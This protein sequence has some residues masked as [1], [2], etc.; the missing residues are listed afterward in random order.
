[1]ADSNKPIVPG[2]DTVGTVGE[3]YLSKNGKTYECVAV[4]DNTTIT[5]NGET[6]PRVEY[7]WVCTDDGAGGGAFPF[8]ISDSEPITISRTK[9]ELIAAIDAGKTPIGY[10]LHT[11]SNGTVIRLFHFV[12]RFNATDGTNL[13]FYFSDK[14]SS[15]VLDIQA[16]GTI[17]RTYQNTEPGGSGLPEGATAFQQLVTDSKG[18]AV[19]DDRPGGY[20]QKIIGDYVY[21]KGDDKSAFYKFCQKNGYKIG[22]TITVVCNGVTYENVPI[23]ANDNGGVHLEQ[24]GVFSF[25]NVTYWGGGTWGSASDVFPDGVVEA[26]FKNVHQLNDVV[27]PEKYMAYVLDKKLDKSGGDVSGKLRVAGEDVLLQI[28]NAPME[29]EDEKKIY[30]ELFLG[31]SNVSIRSTYWPIMSGGHNC[32]QLNS[33]GLILE[34]T[35]SDDVETGSSEDFGNVFFNYPVT[36]QNVKT[37]TVSTD[38][39]NMGY[40]DDTKLIV[41]SSTAGSTKKFKITVDDAGTL[42]A[43][44]ITT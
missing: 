2:G 33:R 5:P 29:G 38:A 27:I 10:W 14:T 43:T 40:V 35:R 24:S 19:W 44:E 30:H 16:D 6:I 15:G 22:D 21:A 39:A 31:D 7:V 8:D 9:E 18:S 28:V 32:L 37:P 26:T 34:L 4:I 20:T 41:Q 11:Q 13:T 36:I 23:T 25:G 42:S 17:K 12:K 3:I 1:M